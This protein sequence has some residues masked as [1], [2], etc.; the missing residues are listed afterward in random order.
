MR[1][2]AR[3]VLAAALALGLAACGFHLAGTRPLP[4]PLQSVY[5]DVI[6]P[7]RVSEPPLETALRARLLR[8]GADVTA[9]QR[10]A[11]TV[12][13]LSNLKEERRV[14]SVGADGKAVEFQLTTRVRFELIGPDR[15]LV[16]QGEL[17]VARDY[18]FK[19]DEVL[20]KEAEQARLRAYIQDELAELLL[21]RLEAVL[22]RPAAD[23]QAGSS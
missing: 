20:A 8:R 4:P 13:R 19:A 11:R 10:A 2:K 12:L 6:A 18:S 14:L 21:L 5:I 3:A 9:S 7:Y 15:L 1:A 23:G 16:P 22:S 17:S